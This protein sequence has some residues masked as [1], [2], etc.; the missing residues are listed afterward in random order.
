M[1]ER[2][3]IAPRFRGPQDSANGGYTCGVVARSIDPAAADVSLRLPP[4]LDRPLEV[5]AANGGAVLRDGDDVVAEGSALDGLDVEPPEPVGVDEAEAASRRSSLFDRHPFPTCFVCGPERASGDGLRVIPGPVEGRDV[6]AAPWTPDGS[7]TADDGSIPPEIEW[8]ALDCPSGNAA[9]MLIDGIGVSVLA[10]LA[11]RIASPVEPG[12]R[13]VAM[14]WVVGRDG[15]KAHSA[16]AVFTADGE[17]VG[18]A[19]AVWIELRR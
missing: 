4:P 13:H 8:A 16:S 2:V 3:T 6:V 10:R 12:A 1:S 18:L 11:A 17:L 7:L 5:E 14:G 9:M 19:R 15:R